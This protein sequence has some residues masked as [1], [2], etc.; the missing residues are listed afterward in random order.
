MSDDLR[1]NY[2]RAYNTRVGFGR[3]PALLLID[4]CHAYFA[5]ECELYAEVTDAFASALRV[6]SA[7]RAAGVPSIGETTLI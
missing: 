7:A 2:E 6:R 1:A 4:Y 5:P 3:K